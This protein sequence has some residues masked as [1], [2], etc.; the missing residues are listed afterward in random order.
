MS[1]IRTKILPVI[2][3]V[4]FVLSVM[5]ATANAATSGTSGKTKW[6]YSNNTITF[7]GSGATGSYS[8]KEVPWMTE[9]GSGATTSLS[10]KKVISVAEDELRYIEKASN[11]NLY[12][13]RANAGNRNY[14]KY[15]AELF[16]SLQ[17]N[18]WC[19][20]FVSWCVW[21]AAGKN[22]NTANKALCGGLHSAYTP[23]SANKYKAAGRWTTT[24]PKVG[25]Q[26][27]FQNGTRI[28]HTGLV[29]KVTDE[30]IYTIEGNTLGGKHSS[31]N[32][33]EVLRKMYA[34]SYWKIAGYGHPIYNGSS[35]AEDLPITKVEFKE[36]V[37]ELGGYLFTHRS[38]VKTVVIPKSVKEIAPYAFS[39]CEGIKD[40]YYA[41]T[42]SEWKK[43]KVG[44]IGNY[45]IEHADMHYGKTA[46][47][48]SSTN[49]VSAD[50]KSQTSTGS[51]LKILSQPSSITVEGN[52][53]HLFSVTTNALNA[54][55]RWQVKEGSGK[56]WRFFSEKWTARTANLHFTVTPEMN[57][58]KFRCKVTKDGDSVK[59]KSF[60]V[61]VAGA[62]SIT[63]QPSNTTAS[64][65]KKAVFK[66]K[67]NK[68][69]QYQW[70]YKK[71]GSK[72]WKKIKSTGTAKSPNLKIKATVKKNGYK[73]RCKITS[74]NTVVYSKTV[75]LKVK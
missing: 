54:T 8:G 71:T 10:A 2:F 51:A 5:P 14:T 46:P 75:S 7:S 56:K 12:D 21:T 52:K 42:A 45:Y 22:Q 74:G 36:G 3:S 1:T 9:K 55:Y 41:G 73:Y 34:R 58:W 61:K 59:S 38:D 37:T 67:T 72:K 26:V 40:V 23:N 19:D 11:S 31:A 63:K 68:A 13:K 50:G 53:L 70:Q 35:E 66:V 17:S 44:S 6:T 15:A 30:A 57:G 16:P 62:L 69:A 39:Y 64:A 25:D 47:A 18:P 49:E 33:G 28:S 4:L 27:F 43:V 48:V 60:T 24:N 20:M 32:G 29:Y 65:G